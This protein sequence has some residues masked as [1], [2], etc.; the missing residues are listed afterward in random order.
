MR[1]TNEKVDELAQLARLSFQ[2][3]EKDAIRADLEKILEMC[4]K[5]N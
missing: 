5:L 3:E 1:I 4:E 2:G